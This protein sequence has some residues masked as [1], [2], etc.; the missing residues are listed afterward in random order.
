M[1]WKPVQQLMSM[2]SSSEVLQGLY[3]VHPITVLEYNT[4]G[5]RGQTPHPQYSPNH[6]LTNTIK[7]ILWNESK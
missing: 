3:S 6:Q 5:G 7:N 4:G 2:K 1:K